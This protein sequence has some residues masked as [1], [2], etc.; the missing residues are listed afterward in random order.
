MSLQ[1]T[2]TIKAYQ[3]AIEDNGKYPDTSW[4][5]AMYAKRKA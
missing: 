1:S 4:S 3:Q 5:R 2:T